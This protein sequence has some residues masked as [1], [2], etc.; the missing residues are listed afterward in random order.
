VVE[1]LMSRLRGRYTIVIVA[2]NLAQARRIANYAAFFW[3]KG[4]AGCL[5]EFAHCR[6]IFDRRRINLP[7]LT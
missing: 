4:H 5:I 7:P 1:D 2:H 6:Q 3:I